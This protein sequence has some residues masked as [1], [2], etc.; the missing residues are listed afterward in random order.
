MALTTA[1]ANLVAN[2]SGSIFNRVGLFNTSGSL[3]ATEQSIGWT[4][5]SGGTIT[6]TSSVQFTIPS[7]QTV[8]SIVV[9]N[10][11]GGALT[12]IEE[13]NI[14]DEPYP[15]GGFFTVNSGTYTFA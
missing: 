5:A 15:N 9:L 1:G 6:L 14:T 8:A 11:T 12:T 2:A 4:S 3:V 10:D 13:F 7:G